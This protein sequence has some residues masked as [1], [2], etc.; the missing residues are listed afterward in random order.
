MTGCVWFCR[1]QFSPMA[2]AR[3]CIEV[4]RLCLEIF[5][6]THPRLHGFVA[7]VGGPRSI[8]EKATN[9]EPGLLAR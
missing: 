7:P 1:S 8:P 5:W 2:M 3:C 4:D 6:N 9:S